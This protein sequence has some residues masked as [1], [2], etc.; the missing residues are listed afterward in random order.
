MLP[1]DL[2]GSRSK[3]RFRNELLWG[4]EKLYEVYKT[5]EDFCIIF[6]YACDIELHFSDRFEFYQLKTSNKGEAYTIGKISNPDK[7]G[8]SIL[9][10]VY[11]L[12]K[13]IDSTNE[14]EVTK[15]AIV[16]NV[17]LKT[18]DEV[19]HASVKELNLNSLKDTK[20]AVKKADRNNGI[21]E[22]QSKNKIIE[23][24]KVEIQSDTIDLSGVYYIN[25]SLDLIN[26]ENTLL[27]AT[28]KF[29]EEI[30]GKEA[31][32][33][34]TLYRVLQ[35]II[36]EKACYELKCENYKEVEKYKGITRDEF[37]A[38]LNKII[39]T[40]DNY[41][42]E[43][44]QLIKDSY[45]GFLEQ[46]KLMKGISFV[47]IELNKNLILNS[48][49]EKIIKY[50]DDNIDKLNDEFEEI[51]NKL[52]QEFEAEFPI[53]YSKYE[54]MALFILLLA[55]YKEDLNEQFNN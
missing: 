16:V 11:A 8:N 41:V 2:S 10:K 44:N 49:K 15:I 28:V 18:L 5:E 32:K 42:K 12:K 30:T 37:E 47:V 26:P 43:A 14:F 53:E 20:Q 45:K 46:T 35:D 23:N 25:S 27:G 7:Q 38:V 24:L 21:I 54:K 55:K 4:L 3:N 22:T 36:N 6:D 17:P 19:V 1:Y 13:I 33:V 51:V 50:I 31:S 52:L 34:R 29:I 40:S 48:L 39:I 9:G